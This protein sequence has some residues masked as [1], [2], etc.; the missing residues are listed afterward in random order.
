MRVKHWTRSH[1]LRQHRPNMGRVRTIPLLICV[2]TGCV[3]SLLAAC[4]SH[5]PPSP[6][7]GSIENSQC[8]CLD[9]NGKLITTPTLVESSGNARLDEAALKLAQTG[10]CNR[11][12]GQD[13]RATEQNGNQGREQQK[14]IPRCVKFK[15][16]FKL[17]EQPK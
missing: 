5:P 12:T 15:I 7:S 8:G 1:T 9:E 4:A 14:P 11:D 10:H 2:L 6:T 3:V 17:E 13:N 16:K